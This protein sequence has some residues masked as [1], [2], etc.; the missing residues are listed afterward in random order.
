MRSPPKLAIVVPCYNEDEGLASTV[1]TLKHLLSSLAESGKCTSDSIIILVDDGSQDAT[2]D[3][4]HREWIKAPQ[5]VVGLR[6]AVNGGHQNALAAGLDYATDHAAATISI[7]ADLQDDLSALAK[8][9][10]HYIGGAEIVLGVKNSRT[11]DSIPKRFTAWGF[12]ALLRSMGVKVQPQHADFRLMSSAALR[13]LRQF[14]EYHLFLRGFPF[15]LHNKVTTVHYDISDRKVGTS[16][17]TLRKMISLALNG[18]TSF[19]IMPLRVITLLGFVIFLLSGIFSVGAI[20]TALRGEAV[21]GWASTTV[22]LYLLGG[23]NMLCLGI[24]GEYIGKTYMEAKRRPR[25]LV[26]T[27]LSAPVE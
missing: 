17:Y 13:N 8:M 2:W 12:Y 27:T 6:L 14:P 23:V 5:S 9:L 15:L 3:V 25:Y 19:S 11:G 26:D 7:D 20:I 24:V 22:P 21:P 10:D 1:S 4:I 16:K 18:I